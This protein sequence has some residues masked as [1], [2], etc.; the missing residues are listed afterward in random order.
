MLGC[1][2]ASLQLPR[3]HVQCQD[4]KGASMGGISALRGKKGLPTSKEMQFSLKE[5]L[6]ELSGPE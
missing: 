4:T 2:S 3:D 1:G 6:M 5:G